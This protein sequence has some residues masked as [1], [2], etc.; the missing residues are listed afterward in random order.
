MQVICLKFKIR[1]KHIIIYILIIVILL[2]GTS[3]AYI[4][5]HSTP[6]RAIRTELFKEGHF[7][8]AFNTHIHKIG[9]DSDYGQYYACGE[10]AVGADHIACIN[11][12]DFWYINWQGTGGA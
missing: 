1:P 9:V 12:N 5:C 10:P 3:K 7:I 4:F 2:L 11:K 8:S 6:Q